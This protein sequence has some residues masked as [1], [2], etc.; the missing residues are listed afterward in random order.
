MKKNI[1]NI[2]EGIEKTKRELN[3]QLN[4]NEREEI[5]SALQKNEELNKKHQHQK[6]KKFN[7]LKCKSKTKNT[8]ETNG[9]TY[10]TE[11]PTSEHQRLLYYS[12]LK[13]ISS[14]NHS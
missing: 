11:T 12:V 10:Q 3:Q 2:S 1:E 4:D 5:I 6:R 14:T 9:P 8:S 13:R 7:Y